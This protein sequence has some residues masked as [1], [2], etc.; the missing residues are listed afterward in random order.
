MRLRVQFLAAVGLAALTA[1]AASLS[2]SAKER[3]RP[4]PRAA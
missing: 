4:P 2:A 3:R 1:G